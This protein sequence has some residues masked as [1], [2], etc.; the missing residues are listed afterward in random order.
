[1]DK[2][3]PKSII[4]YGTIW[5]IDCQRA[6][7]FLDQSRIQYQW[8]DID[9]DYEARKIVETINH[10]MRSVP[11]IIFSDGTTLVEPDNAQLRNKLSI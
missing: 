2:G 11:T 1:M 9:Q 10:G 7:T 8:I 5:C 3:S 6:K 4:M